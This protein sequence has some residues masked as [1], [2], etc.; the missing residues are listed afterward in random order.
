MLIFIELNIT[1]ENKKI[2]WFNATKYGSIKPIP[3]F[4]ETLI[5]I[6]RQAQ[7]MVDNASPGNDLSYLDSWQEF[8]RVTHNADS[9]DW[10]LQVLLHQAVSGLHGLSMPEIID[11]EDY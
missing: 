5:D 8:L 11:E 3:V 9:S 2:L 4:Q 1:M 6:Q 7:E 10:R